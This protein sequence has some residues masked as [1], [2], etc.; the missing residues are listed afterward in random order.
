MRES[1]TA[2]V[3]GVVSSSF[4]ISGLSLPSKKRR[5]NISAMRGFRRPSAPRSQSRIS[6]EECARSGRRWARFGQYRLQIVE[7]D[8]A[9]VLAGAHQ[10][11]RRIDR[12]AMQKAA[13]AGDGLGVGI[14]LQE[15]EEDGLQNVF[16]V[17]GVAGDPVGGAK[18]HGVVLAKDA[19]QVGGWVRGRLHV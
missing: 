9:N 10:I 3:P 2:T 8:V 19:F 1:V 18:H 5:A 16:G 14:A 11:Y 4:A 13:Y 17:G 6:P 15:T 7:R 12:G